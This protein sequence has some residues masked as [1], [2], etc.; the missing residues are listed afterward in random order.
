M[1]VM[2]TGAT[3][4]LGSA[5]VG[6]LLAEPEVELVLGVGTEHRGAPISPRMVYLRADLTHR[7]EVH[8]LIHRAA[9][10]HAI[11][12]VV[13]VG[14]HRNP[15]D[16]GTRVHAQSVDSVRALVLACSEHATIRRFVYRSFANVYAQPHATTTLIDEDTPLEL[17]H[18]APQW[19]RDRVEADLTVCGYR[20]GSLQISVLRCAEVVAPDIGSQLWDYLSSR[21]CFRPAGFD[22]MINVLAIE[23]AAS[24]F[25]AAVRSSVSGVFNVCGAETLPLSRAISESNRTAIAIPGGLLAPLYGLRRAATGFEFR[26]DLNARRFHLGSLL[27]GARALGKLG[28]VPRTRVRWPRPWWRVLLERLAETR[29]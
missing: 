28:Y 18:R 10:A 9:R 7:R 1:R 5:I 29:A 6:A 25:V 22:P 4:P 12:T 11:D 23:D 20:G 17:D 16:D 8:D 14:Q 26:Y 24:A 2:V 19:L 15:H 27:D 3:A 21:I 13:H